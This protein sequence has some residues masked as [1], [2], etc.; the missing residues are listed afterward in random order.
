MTTEAEVGATAALEVWLTL[1]P[2]HAERGARRVR[3]RDSLGLSPVTSHTDRSG[4]AAVKE[5]S[6]FGMG[7]AQS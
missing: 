1:R 2:P 7:T 5:G 4:A 3:G 6:I